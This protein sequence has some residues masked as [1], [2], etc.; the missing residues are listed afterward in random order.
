MAVK[1]KICGLTNAEDAA[2]AVEAGADAVGFAHRPAIG[3]VSVRVIVCVAD[4]R[5]CE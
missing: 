2:V 1:V 5:V 3:Q 4:R